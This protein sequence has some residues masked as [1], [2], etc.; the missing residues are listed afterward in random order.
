MFKN[1]MSDAAMSVYEQVM[2]FFEQLL[3][4][5]K[6]LK[7]GI[8]LDE[9]TAKGPAI[10]SCFCDRCLKQGVSFIDTPFCLKCGVKFHKSIDENHLC[11]TCLKRPLNLGRV[12]A[13]AEYKGI[14]KE[15]IQLFK[16]QS[17]ISIATVFEYFLFQTFL[18]HFDSLE[19]DLIMPV[20]L[21]KTKLKQRG[22]NQ[23]F[24]IIRH[25]VTLYQQNLK[26]HP[27]WQIATTSLVRVKKTES[28]TGFDVKH[29]K[30]NLK[31]AFKVA[32]KKGIENKH[33]L[34]IDDV[35]TTGATCS[36]AGSELLKHGAKSV[37]ALV[38]ART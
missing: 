9:K 37:D 32:D 34:L 28:Q 23:A 20:P 30:D 5:P 3:Y 25:F 2:Q 26:Q 11:E 7:C 33:I 1:S 29:R 27:S 31:H 12:R 13:A 36:E 18:N 17:K 16:Y 24:L 38:I 19:I 6:C 22:Y 10:E 15:G 21:H 4:P 14:I 8:Y 35:F